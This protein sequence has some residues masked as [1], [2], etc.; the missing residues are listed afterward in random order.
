MLK[1]PI[2]SCASSTGMVASIVRIGAVM[3]FSTVSRPSGFPD[4]TARRTMSVSVTMPT[5]CFPFFT[6]SA[7]IRA[8][9]MVFAALTTEVV[10]LTDRG[11]LVMMFAIADMVSSLQRM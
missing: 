2:M 5:N 8:A 3:I 9:F 1:S 11:F 7:L 10:G 6:N 4:D